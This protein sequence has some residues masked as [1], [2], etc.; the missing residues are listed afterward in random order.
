M[1]S[2]N[3]I[4]SSYLFGEKQ[5]CINIQFFN[6][7]PDFHVEKYLVLVSDRKNL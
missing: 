1:T 3:V 2:Y 5:H 6:Y 7:L 4:W